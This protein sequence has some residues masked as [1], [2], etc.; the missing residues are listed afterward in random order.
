MASIRVPK[1]PNKAVCC[2]LFR[3]LVESIDGQISLCHNAVP[4]WLAKRE[5]AQKLKD[6][7]NIPGFNAT[8]GEFN[9]L[10]LGRWLKDHE[11]VEQAKLLGEQNKPADNE[12]REGISA[13]IIAWVNRRG[14]ICR[15][16]VS[17]HLNDLE[18]DLADMESPE[19]LRFIEQEVDEL[20]GRAELDLDSKVRD[21][22]N[23]LTVAERD[24][25]EE[26]KDFQVFRRESG[27]RRSPDYSGR[28][29]AIWYITAFFVVELLL[30]ATMLMDANP[31]GLLGSAVQMG[32]IGAVNIWIMG[33]YMGGIVRQIHHVQTVRK[34]LFLLLAA[35]VVSFVVCFN[36]MVGHFRDS[37][38]A[39][40]DDPSADLLSVGSDTFERFGAGLASFD[41]FQSGLLALLGLLFFGVSAWKWLDRD[42]HYPD[43]GRR[44]RRLEQKMG[45]YRRRFNQATKNLEATFSHY[46]NQLEDVRHRLVTRLT[47]WREHRLQGNNIIEDYPTNLAQ[48]QHD[49]NE[50]LGAYY[51]ANRSTRTEPEPAWFADPVKIDKEILDPPAF[52]TPEQTSL[53]NVADLVDEAIKKLQRTFGESTRQFRTLE[54]AMKE[55]MGVK[56]DL[57]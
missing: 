14:R 3:I 47:R 46:E 43:Y 8:T 53:K 38:Q 21:G 20:L 11:I 34:W 28:K 4:F 13:R 12:E 26:E 31:F 51:T 15:Q 19:Q 5:M 40:L 24:L 16:N 44:H 37:M 22:S 23:H 45:D 2:C 57:A 25:R 48:Y 18:R 41:S 56:E 36:L 50:L 1:A 27:L 9:Q 30:N 7:D 6:W 29:S 54:E 55:S 52:N 35:L 33:W 42:D 49:L 10:D 39:I 17:N 32:L